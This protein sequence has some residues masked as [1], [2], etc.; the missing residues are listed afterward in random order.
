VI[1]LRK[2]EG[3]PEGN[4][5]RKLLTLLAEAHDPAYTDGLVR[6]AQQLLG[7]TES[8]LFLG[9]TDRDLGLLRQR[10]ALRL[11]LETA[12]WDLQAPADR[13]GPVTR[14]PFSVWLD[15][16]RSPFNVG[17]LIRTAE[18][19][20][21]ESVFLSPLT[22]GLSHPRTRR[23]AMGAETLLSVETFSLTEM[24]DRW[25][26]RPVFA[27]ELGGVS[28]DRFEFP[29]GGLV[30]AGGEELGLSP[31][32][33]SWADRSFGRVSLPLFGRKASLNVGVAFGILAAA[34]TSR[35]SAGGL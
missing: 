10:L 17:S 24:Q 26:D 7:E 18:A 31:E 22:P 29:G 12:D 15:D 14:F 5:G 16:L 19:Y 25:G 4:R 8:K 30:L 6:L 28:V 3:L 13:F 11:G 23:S 27:L 34:W 33:L 9:P 20:G 21:F 35:R 1:T 32:A 2:L